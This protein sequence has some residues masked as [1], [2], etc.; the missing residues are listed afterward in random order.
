MGNFVLLMSI[1]LTLS[2]VPLLSGL[3]KHDKGWLIAIR[4]V[5]PILICSFIM[6]SQLGSPLNWW[7]PFFGTLQEANRERL[8]ERERQGEEPEKIQVEIERWVLTSA[9]GRFIRVNPYTY[10]FLRK[11]D[12]MFFKLAW[13]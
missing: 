1:L 8:A 5:Q 10:K 9:K 4:V 6:F 11:G 3:A 13:G 2:G 7:R 12:A